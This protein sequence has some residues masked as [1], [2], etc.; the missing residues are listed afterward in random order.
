MSAMLVGM[1]RDYQTMKVPEPGAAGGYLQ[2]KCGQVLSYRGKIGARRLEAQGSG[3]CSTDR[4][5]PETPC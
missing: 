4:K 2:G 3:Q 1:Q 5:Y